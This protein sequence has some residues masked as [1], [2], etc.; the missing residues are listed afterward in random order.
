MK[1]SFM[2]KPKKTENVRVAN[3]TLALQGGIRN[4]EAFVKTEA[5]LI[6]NLIP[7]GFENNK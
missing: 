7:A 3:E 6:A 2:P 5:D 4:Q 1:A